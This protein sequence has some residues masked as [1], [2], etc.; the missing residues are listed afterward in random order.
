VSGFERVIIAGQ[1]LA[2]EHPE[3]ASHAHEVM[4]QL[5][6]CEIMFAARLGEPIPL[7]P[8]IPREQPVR[9]TP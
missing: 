8:S 3:L 4:N 5:W 7:P 9:V 6:A 1:R 2:D